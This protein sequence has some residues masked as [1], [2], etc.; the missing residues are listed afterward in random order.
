[1]EID[2]IIELKNNTE[3]QMVILKAQRLELENQIKKLQNIINECEL[4]T[5][6]ISKYSTLS[7]SKENITDLIVSD[8]L[9]L[10]DA[11]DNGF[12]PLV[13]NE[14]NKIRRQINSS[15]M[16]VLKREESMS[17]KER[18]VNEIANVLIDK[19]EVSTANRVKDVAIE[20]GIVE[21]L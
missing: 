5:I 2:K 21:K 19:E 6:L 12:Q 13:Q 11:F 20:S 4:S 1:M 7:S 9:R 10:M 18:T 16:E 14:V 15:A 17:V 8:N 3:E